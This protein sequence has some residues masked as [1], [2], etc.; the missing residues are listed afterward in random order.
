M[1]IAPPALTPAASLQVDAC[2]QHVGLIGLFA[3]FARSWIEELRNTSD[4]H[5][6]ATFHGGTVLH[7]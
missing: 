7:G 6:M 1:Q 4:S 2:I 3:L 5:R